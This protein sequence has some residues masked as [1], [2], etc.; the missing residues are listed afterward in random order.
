MKTSKE[1]KESLILEAY[2]VAYRLKKNWRVGWVTM[3]ELWVEFHKLAPKVKLS[4]L[5]QTLLELHNKDFLKYDFSRGSACVAGVQ[6]YGIYAKNGVLYY[7]N[8]RQDNKIS[9]ERK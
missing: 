7:F 3:K 4:E 8:L 5:K 6:R 2:T 1:E 9:E